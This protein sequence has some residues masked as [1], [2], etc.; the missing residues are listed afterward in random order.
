MEWNELRN[1][2]YQVILNII[3]LLWRVRV[4]DR[5]KLA[6]VY[7]YDTVCVCVLVSL[8]RP[9]K[10]G[11]RSGG[12]LYEKMSAMEYRCVRYLH[13]VDIPMT[14]FPSTNNNSNGAWSM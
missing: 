9:Q 5:S 1:S 11:G 7:Q 8:R 14:G 3:P 2:S 4:W 13:S 12:P 6:L 10:R